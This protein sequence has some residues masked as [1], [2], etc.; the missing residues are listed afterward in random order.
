MWGER[1]PDFH[2]LLFVNGYHLG[3][4]WEKNSLL[5]LCCC[6]T[7]FH[8]TLRIQEKKIIQ[9]RLFLSWNLRTLSWISGFWWWNSWPFEQEKRKWSEVAEGRLLSGGLP[10]LTKALS[11]PIVQ[12]SFVQECHWWW[13]LCRQGY[14]LWPKF[15]FL[16]S[17]EVIK[18]NLSFNLGLVEWGG[19][20]WAQSVVLAG[21]LDS[22]PCWATQ[23]S[24]AELLKDWFIPS[25]QGEVLTCAQQ[26]WGYNSVLCSCTVLLLGDFLMLPL[27]TEII[28][29]FF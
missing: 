24:C 8:P 18:V 23:E 9:R 1:E 22:S 4:S 7:V 10:G 12:I 29:F 15:L 26:S 14:R 2:L 16:V 20:V 13:E 3:F 17:H 6:V 11:R 5:T 21:L 25:R 27:T 28:V 19:E